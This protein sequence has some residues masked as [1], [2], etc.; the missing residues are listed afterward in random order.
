MYSPYMTNPLHEYPKETYT[1]AAQLKEMK[2]T[3]I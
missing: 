2:S 3:G 1:M